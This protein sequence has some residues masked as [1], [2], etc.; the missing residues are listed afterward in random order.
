MHRKE[1]TLVGM[2]TYQI[3]R[4]HKDIRNLYISVHLMYMYNVC[5]CDYKTLILYTEPL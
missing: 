4:K 2:D 5:T 1:H 3:Q